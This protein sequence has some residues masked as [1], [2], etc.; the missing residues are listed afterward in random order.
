MLGLKKIVLPNETQVREGVV[1]PGETAVATRPR[2]PRTKI[3]GAAIY[4]AHVEEGCF[5]IRFDTRLDTQ[6]VWSQ[7]NA[8]GC[9]GS[10]GLHVLMK[11]HPLAS[12]VFLYVNTLLYIPLWPPNLPPFGGALLRGAETALSRPKIVSPK[13]VWSAHP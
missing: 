6:A 12:G 11:L 5:Y 7:A 1:P 13:S 8:Q 2:R 9:A 4:A 10:L 3:L